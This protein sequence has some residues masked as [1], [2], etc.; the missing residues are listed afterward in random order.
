MNL[1]PG[2]ENPRPADLLAAYRLGGLL[3]VDAPAASLLYG[4]NGTSLMSFQQRL[5][6]HGSLYHGSDDWR[7]FS[8]DE[9][10]DTNA[11]LQALL[12]CGRE[13]IARTVSQCAGGINRISPAKPGDTVACQWCEYRSICRF[14]LSEQ[15]QAVRRPVRS[16]ESELKQQLLSR[17][18]PDG[19]GQ[20]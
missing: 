12:Q 8:A 3:A 4:S 13:S 20:R 16:T 6:D 5:K 10:G 15:P 7:V 1:L 9:P 17:Y 11:N 19:E 2:M 18:R 14:E